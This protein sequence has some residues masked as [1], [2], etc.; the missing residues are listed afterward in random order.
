M[1]DSSLSYPSG[2]D[3]FDLNRCVPQPF[4]ETPLEVRFQVSRLIRAHAARPM[5]LILPQ[6]DFKTTHCNVIRL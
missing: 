6:R 2:S 5:G 1:A 4:R 3:Q